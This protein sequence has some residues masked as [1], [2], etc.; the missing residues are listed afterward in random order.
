VGPALGLLL[1]RYAPGWRTKVRESDSLDS[2]LISALQFQPPKNPQELARERAELY[3][4]RAVALAETERA[5]THR[6]LLADIEKKFLEGPTLRFPTAAEM[7]RTFNPN[8]LVTFPPHGTFYP[9][10]TFSANWG[11]LQVESGGALVGPDN[12]SVRVT[13]PADIESRPVRG[14]GWTLQ[15]APGWTI[16]RSEN[17]NGY[18]V[19]PPEQK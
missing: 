16:R 2:L 13:A 14:A 10:G 19:V 3:G 12:R 15:L 1:D 5:E 7:N 11:K 18:E 8:A 17:A 4:Y 9:T 6:A